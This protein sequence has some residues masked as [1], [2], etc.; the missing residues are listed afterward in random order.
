MNRL[1][2][3]FSASAP[4]SF[5]DFRVVPFL[6]VLII[7]VCCFEKVTIDSYFF[8]KKNR[9]L[10]LNLKQRFLAIMLLQG[11]KQTEGSFFNRRHIANRYKS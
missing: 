3:R 7:S 5:K 10:R 6:L 8:Q 2:F 9:C 4:Y 1:L 11:T